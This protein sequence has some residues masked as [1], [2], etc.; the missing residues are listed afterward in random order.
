MPPF[1]RFPLSLLFLYGFVMAQNECCKHGPRPIVGATGIS[2][3]FGIAILI[4]LSFFMGT[5]INAVVNDLI[6]Q[7]MAVTLFNSLGQKGTI[8]LWAFL[9]IAQCM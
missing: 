1:S 4:V 8:E 3:I 9:V 5:N 7:P 6:R 2:G